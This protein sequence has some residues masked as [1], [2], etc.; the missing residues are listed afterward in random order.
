MGKWEIPAPRRSG[1]IALSPCPPLANIL[2]C[3]SGDGKSLKFREKDSD[4]SIRKGN[5]LPYH[6]GTSEE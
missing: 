4:Y 5:F 3:I 1:L 2:L 6:V